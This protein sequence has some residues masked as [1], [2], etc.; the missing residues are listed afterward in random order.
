MIRYPLPPITL[1]DGDSDFVGAEPCV[2][3]DRET[4]EILGAFWD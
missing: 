4:G 2:L 1:E 3:I